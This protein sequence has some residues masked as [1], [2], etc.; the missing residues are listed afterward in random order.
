[1]KENSYSNRIALNFLTATAVLIV[2][3]FSLIYLMV[4]QTM[5]SRLNTILDKECNEVAGGITLTGN[6][7]LF[8]DQAE[9]S[10]WEHI[11]M[12]VNPIF[13]Q[14]A[15]HTGEIVKS[16]ANLMGTKLGLVK[17]ESSKI[18]LNAMLSTGKIRLVQTTLTNTSGE[19]AGYLTIAVPLEET[20][21]VLE[22]L[23]MVLLLTFPIALAVLYYITRFI[24]QRS[25]LPVKLLTESAAKI[26]GKNLNRRITLPR[27][28]DELYTLTDTINSL[29]D[30]VE[31]TMAREKQFSSDASHELRT[32][33]SALKGTLELMVRKPRD[34]AYYHEKTGTC[35]AEVNRM[36][37]L[38]DQLLLLARYESSVTNFDL[39]TVNLK[40]IVLDIIAR[41]ADILE[42]KGIE[43]GL[44][45]GSGS[46][47]LTN[48]F[49]LEQIIEN[50]LTNAVKY[51]HTNGIIRISATLINEHTALTIRDAG[52]GMTGQEISKIFDRFYRADESRSFQGRGYG[53]GL[54]IVKKFADLLQITIRV[55]SQPQKGSSFTLTF[56][57]TPP[58]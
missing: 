25:I 51:S 49:M 27:Q 33:L 12:E 38:V 57:V 40:N 16:S 44:S 22:N 14:I 23:L 46:A 30:R 42:Q 1:M 2:I 50:I 39:T 58:V 56:P 3:I 55:E 52:I 9:W 28:K 20:Q 15:D 26:T 5:Y 8:N 41:Q 17:D 7:F 24:A 47:V 13:I 48:A 54:S 31:D 18:F 45:I 21:Q 6:H 43:L 10:E 37:V 34:L 32:P 4:Y 36:S 11:Q 19:T 53:L 35:L 29:L